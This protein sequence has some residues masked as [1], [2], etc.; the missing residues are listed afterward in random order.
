M[1]KSF[2]FPVVLLLSFVEATSAFCFT[3]LGT[4]PAGG[5][6]EISAVAATPDRIVTAMRDGSNDLRL[7]AWDA[8]VD[9]NL[10]RRGTG[11]AGT[12]SQI[13]LAAASAGRV[14][15]AMRDGS[16][17]LRLIAWDVDTNGNLTRRGTATAGSI[18]QIAIAAVSATR[19]IAAMRD[20][21]NDLRLIAWDVDTN[22]N[23]TRRGTA[24][25]GSISEVSIV[26][27]GVDRVVTA[28]RDGSNDLRLIAWDVDANGNVTRRSTGTAGAIS[29]VSIVALGAQ[30]VGTAVRDGSSN[31]RLITWDTATRY[32]FDVRR[33]TTSTLP[34]AT[35]DSI[36]TD[37]S[38]L[39]Q[40]SDGAD[41]TAC[42][43][44]LV[45]NGNVGAF[46]TGTGT[47]NSEN[48]FDDVIA[49]GGQVKVVNAI[50]WCGQLIPNVIGCSPVGGRSLAVVRFTA[51]Q[52]GNLWA[53]EFGHDTGL[54]HRNDANAVMNPTIGTTRRRVTLAECISYETW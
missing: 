53:H 19:V 49:L 30:R 20:G 2:A 25:A 50:N 27:M 13:A 17:D 10:I 37:A 4:A 23:L 3:R 29:R 36:L 52:E 6:S 48:D 32:A 1:R 24:T 9:G 8:D 31:L 44:T 45:R 22:G 33:H 28:I 5:I 46:A 14:V 11:T 26:A 43:I 34:N 40:I 21:S 16:N 12:I 47:I 41:D 38:N 18:S 7:I 54:N 35:A 39:L 42:P 15:A 51:N